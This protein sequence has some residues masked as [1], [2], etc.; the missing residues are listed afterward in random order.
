SYC[1]PVVSGG[2]LC[3]YSSRI[4]V[5]VDPETGKRVWRSRYPGDGFLA[6]IDGRLLIATLK[7]TLHVG[8][9]SVDGFEEQTSASVFQSGANGEDGM[10]WALPSVSGNRIYLRSLGAIARID[11]ESGEPSQLAQSRESKVSS[12][13]K[14]FLEEVENADDK[15]AVIDRFLAGKS[16]PIIDEEIVHF[17]LRGDH[18][19]VAV[20]SELFGVRQERPMVRV[21]GTD[22]FYFGTPVSGDT[23][24]SYVFY[25]DFHAMPDPLNSNRFESTLLAGEMEPMFIGPEQTIEF[26]WFD[27]GSS[28]TSLANLD[29]NPDA[30]KGSVDSFQLDSKML[31]D[32]VDIDVYLPDGYNDSD[33]SYPVVFVHDGKVAQEQGNQ[34]AIVD[35]LVS[36]GAI[37]P[38]VVVFIGRRFYPLQ[39]A[40][41]YVEM[42]TGELLPNIFER[43]RISE[44]RADRACLGGGFGA[45][46][47]MMGTLP[48]SDKVSKIGCHSP[49]AFEL[50]HPVLRMLSTLPNPRCNVLIHW[51]K[52]EFR[53]PAEN[54]NMAKQALAI[55]EILG[56]GKHEVIAKEVPIGTDWPS[57]KTQS[58]EMWKFLAGAP[59]SE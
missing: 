4:L 19:D 3:S 14:A 23:R 5:A 24:A 33:Q 12:G 8:S 40:D 48:S 46:L 56:E 50:L 52:Y 47:A 31:R 35:E 15:P 30:I 27:K 34:V 11:I 49:F 55:A 1:V 6:T 51:G 9:V 45:T 28:T 18:Q 25:A 2:L 29:K 17:V 7:G 13:F 32:R 58:E 26:S 36:N 57:W 10:L 43:Y 37:R 38:V 22:F 44:D 59:E 20:A 54:W 21:K 53:N 42:F 41:G 39:G 16:T